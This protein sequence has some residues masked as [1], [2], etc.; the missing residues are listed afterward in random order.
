M[1]DEIRWKVFQ[2]LRH[3]TASAIKKLE[4]KLED[5][6]GYEGMYYP[7]ATFDE[8][9]NFYQKWFHFDR[10]TRSKM[11]RNRFWKTPYR[12]C[13]NRFYLHNFFSVLNSYKLKLKSFGYDEKKDHTDPRNQ[14]AINHVD[15]LLELF[16]TR[17]RRHASFSFSVC[18]CQHTKYYPRYFF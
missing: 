6:D 12:S 11:G 2:Y 18:P 16:M 5:R 17:R 7:C 8:D 15:D 14:E 13:D 4:E 10:M 9:W 1:N 3:P